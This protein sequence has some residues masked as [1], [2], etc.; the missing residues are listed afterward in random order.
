MPE[1][2][3]IGNNLILVYIYIIIMVENFVR[4]NLQCQVYCSDEVC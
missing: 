1:I 2:I 3:W 4:V